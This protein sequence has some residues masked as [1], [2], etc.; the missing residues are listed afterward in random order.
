MVYL[1][2]DDVLYEIFLSIFRIR[3]IK[4]AICA[5]VM[6]LT[7]QCAIAP[8]G[9]LGRCYAVSPLPSFV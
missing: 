3:F 7:H 4:G 9:L 8:S 1:D 6:V 2:G 5:L